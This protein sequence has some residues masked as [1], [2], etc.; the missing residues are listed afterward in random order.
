MNIDLE[1]RPVGLEMM[2]EAVDITAGCQSNGSNL[3]RTNVAAPI[4]KR[5]DTAAEVRPKPAY[6]FFKRSFDIVISA[7]ASI[8]LLIPVMVIAV[9][10]MCKDPGNPFYMHTRVGRHGRDI[11]ILK[12]RTMRKN[13]DK[14][15]NMLT[16]EQLDEYR[17]E[18]KLDDDPR[19]IGYRKSGDGKTC[20]GA[21]LRRLSIDELPQIIW[22]ICIKGDM[23]V[24]GPRPIL[25]EELERYYTPEQQ[26]A[27]LSV[28]PG[29][30]GYWQAYARNDAKYE[31]GGE[32]QRMELYY[33][34]NMSP[35][36]D[37]RIILRTVKAVFLRSGAK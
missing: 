33:I 17:R 30:T 3:R 19:L 21:K 35:L 10:I 20:F 37:M 16:K 32:R 6:E 25:R 34:E 23:S 1:E 22:N 28:K 4:Q 11:K 18:Y 31:A 27:L 5:N 2:D 13:A 29:L 24:V 12:F 9:M 14:F 8:V 15:E 36:L 26:K 7:L